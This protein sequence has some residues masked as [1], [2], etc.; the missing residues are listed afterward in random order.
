MMNDECHDGAVEVQPKLLLH[1]AESTR[2]F[3]EE[4]LGVERTGHWF[5]WIILSLQRYH[6]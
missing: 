1:E 5:W 2:P 6:E 3:L 4:C